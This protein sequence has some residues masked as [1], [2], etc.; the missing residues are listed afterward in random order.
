MNTILFYKVR[1]T[2]HIVL[3]TVFYL[4]LCYENFNMALSIL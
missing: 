1:I 4:M 3:Y 2:L